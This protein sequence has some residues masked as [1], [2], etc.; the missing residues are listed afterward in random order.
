VTTRLGEGKFVYEVAH[1]WGGL[2][3]GW[4]LGDVAAVAVDGTDRPA[5]PM[6][7]RPFNR[8]THTALSPHG[9]ATDSRG[10]IYVGEVSY[11]AWA[12][13]FPGTERPAQVRSLRKL[14][15]A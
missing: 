13:M 12:G 10:D 14:K 7:G 6:S 1:D 9:L 3:D 11:G 8:C 5:P 4:T 2:P 15:K